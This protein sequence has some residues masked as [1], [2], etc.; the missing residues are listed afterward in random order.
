[1]RRHICNT[2][3]S[4]STAVACILQR[5]YTFSLVCVLI[6]DL[7][8]DRFV[9]TVMRTLNFS[10]MWKKNVYVLL[11]HVNTIKSE[12]CFAVLKCFTY[13][14]QR[15]QSDLHLHWSVKKKKEALLCMPCQLLAMLQD[16]FSTCMEGAT[17][18]NI[19]SSLQMCCLICVICI[20]CVFA[21]CENCEIRFWCVHSFSG[22]VNLLFAR[23]TLLSMLRST[24]TPY[25]RLPLLFWVY[26]CILNM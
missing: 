21:F 22:A 3:T 7:I 17:D 1:M 10:K 14:Q 6:T 18:V 16:V 24:S 8:T 2:A 4:P 25:W 19:A 23:E 13:T 26:A 11:D 20:A 5:F 12:K 15:Y 9:S